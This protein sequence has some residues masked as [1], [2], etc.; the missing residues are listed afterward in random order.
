MTILVAVA[1][2]LGFKGSIMAIYLGE[3]KKS[4]QSFPSLLE[5]KM[6]LQRCFNGWAL[7]LKLIRILLLHVAQMENC[8]TV[9]GMGRSGVKS[10]S[11]TCLTIWNSAS[12]FLK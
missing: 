12:L 9:S 2:S 4:V 6:E 10:Y 3:T 7:E 11:E 8:S 5:S 1:D